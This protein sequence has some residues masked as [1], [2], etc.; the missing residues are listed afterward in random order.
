M[1]IESEIQGLI[2][3]TNKDLLNE[4]ANKDSRVFPTQRDLMAGIVSKHIAR[5]VISPAV[6]NAHDKGLI[7]FHDLDYSP[8]LPF[9]PSLPDGWLV[10]LSPAR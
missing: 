10:L 4:N 8:A 5:Q 7:H 3:R 2:N 6:L 1:T 9:A